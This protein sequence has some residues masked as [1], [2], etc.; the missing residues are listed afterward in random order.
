MSKR[1]SPYLRRA[2]FMAANV[3]VR[4][5][6]D[7]GAFYQR[8]RAEKNI[9]VPV[10]L[11]C[12]ENFASLFTLSFQKIAHISSTDLFRTSTQTICRHRLFCCICVNLTFPLTPFEGG[13]FS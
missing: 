2:L 3:A 12:I 6:P 7:L 11:Q 8:K 1:G 13:D 9:T 10:S 4:F 5:D